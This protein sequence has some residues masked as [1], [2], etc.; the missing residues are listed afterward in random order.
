M[1]T[2]TSK[3]GTRIAYTKTGQGPALII[4]DGALCY[5]AFGPSGPLAKQLDSQ[6][7]VFTYDRRERGESTG[8]PPYA[9]DREVEDLDALIAA[10]GGRA[11]IYGV[12]SGAALALE[13]AHRLGPEKVPRLAVYEAPFI[14]DKSGPARPAGLL[15]HMDRLIAE[16]RRGDAVKAFMKIVGAPSFAIF[17]MRFSPAWSKLTAV[18]HTIPYD[19]RFLEG[20]SAGR[21]LPDNRWAG[22]TMPTLAMDGG[23]SPA[24]MLHAMEA[25]TANLPHAEHRTLPGQTH[26]L[27][28]EAVAPALREFFG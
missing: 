16:G 9:T 18:A 4:V 12:S 15:A 1:P 26:M 7:T 6:F 19:L 22:A 28:P 20:V 14:V 3:D 2:V 23:K 8:T 27:K 21:P 25:V 13:A 11:F 24:S 5:R 17:I 10:A